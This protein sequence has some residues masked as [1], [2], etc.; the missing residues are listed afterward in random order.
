VI[1]S[2]IAALVLAAIDEPRSTAALP[3]F[4]QSAATSTVTFGR[5]S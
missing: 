2:A 3:D 5:A 1:T 4:R